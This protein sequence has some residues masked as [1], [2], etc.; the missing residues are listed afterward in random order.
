M[1]KKKVFGGNGDDDILL[2][3]PTDLADGKPGN[4]KI[5]DQ[6]GSDLMA[7]GGAGDDELVF[8]LASNDG[9]SKTY[10]G[11]SGVDTLTINLTTAE[12]LELADALTSD[13]AAL[14]SLITANTNP[15][16]Q[17]TGQWFQFSAFDLKVKQFENIRLIVDGQELSPE[18]DPV[19]AVDDVNSVDSDTVLVA[20][21]VLVNDSVPDLVASVELDSGPAKGN[22]TFNADGS[23]TFDPNGEFDDLI[24][25]EVEQVT[26]TYKVTDANGDMDIATVTI[27]VIGTNAP[28]DA[29]DDSLNAGESGVT[30]LDVLDNDSDPDND[31]IEIV[32]VTQPSEGTVSFDAGNVYFN[33]GTT[34]EG[35]SDGQTATV[36]FEYT[37]SDGQATDT[38]TVELV[39]QGEGTFDAGAAND[40]GSGTGANGQT[41]AASLTAGAF[42][43]DGTTDAEILVSFGAVVQ[44]EVNVYFVIDVSGSTF[45]FAGG[46]TNVGDLNNDGR[47]DTILDVEIAAYTALL[48]EIASLGFADGAVSVT[49]IPFSTDAGPTQT[50]V[51]DASDDAG[52]TDVEDITAA[53]Q[54]L[55]RVQWTDYLDAL[56]ATEDAINALDPDGDET[57]LVY[58]A[59]DGRPVAP[60][61]GSST[62]AT[63]QDPLDVFNAASAVHATG[64]LVSAFGVGS[65]VP[66]NYLDLVDNTGGSELVTDPNNL[67]AALLGSPIPSSAI[68]DADVFVFDSDGVQTNAI[69]LDPSDFTST[70]LGLSVSLDD[71]GGLDFYLGDQNRLE[72]VVQIDSDDDGLADL[73]LTTDVEVNGVMPESFD[74]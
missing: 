63:Q 42:T 61:N 19:D 49:L 23:Y 33:P 73:T 24:K 37:I 40:S 18:D 64:A 1:P 7:K 6:S 50:F 56:A 57:N 25:D 16:G 43:N 44:P 60:P 58:F 67:T 8:D 34:F 54:A 14:Q 28:P 71:I 12:W 27:D 15:N 65:N 68:I 4:D 13:L 38:A 46:A 32:G 10:L 9:T 47:A 52:S 22:L 5:T 29:V 36:S 3:H 48:E 35:L 17:M 20:G 55:Q 59:S 2:T 69:D 74:V 30:A 70:P 26:F 39:V 72:L 41:V 31:A 21:T 66:Q 62:S 45:S 53:L 11:G 51:L